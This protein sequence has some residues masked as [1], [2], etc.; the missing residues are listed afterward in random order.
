VESIHAP[1]LRIR[2]FDTVFVLPLSENFTFHES[3]IFLLNKSQAN[4][5]DEDQLVYV[6]FSIF[7]SE[8]KFYFFYGIFLKSSTNL[9]LHQIEVIYFRV[10]PQA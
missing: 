1:D 2:F 10:R 9:N 7:S 6:Y 5:Q 8:Q 4:F 3:F